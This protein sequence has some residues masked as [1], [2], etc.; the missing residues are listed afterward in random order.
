M[1]ESSREKEPS[2]PRPTQ[3]QRVWQDCEIGIIYHFDLPVAAGRFE[4]NNAVRET[5]DPKNY[6]PAELDTD[7]W[8]EAA[9]A[10]GAQYA[11]FTATHFN[12]FLQWQTDLYP[13]GMKQS[14]YRNGKGDVVAEFVASCRKANILPGLY[15]STHRNVYWTVWG[16][17]VDWGRGKGTPQQKKFNR[18]AEKMT[19]ELCSRYGPL[20]QIWFD[21]GVKTPQEGG[22]DVLP[23]FE[24]YQRNSVFYHN[25]QR[26]D[27]RWI[28]NENGFAND[29]CWATMP[30]GQGKLSH[31]AASWMPLLGSGDRRGTI[32]SPGMVDV[33]LRGAHGI[34]NWFWSPHQDHAAHSVDAL[35]DMF[36]QSVGRNCNLIIGEVVQPNGRVPTSDIERLRAFGRRI[37]AFFGVPLAETSG[38][39]AEL[40]LRLPRPRLVQY[41]SIM[42]DI[43]FGER[44]DE[45]LLEGLLPGHQWK[46]LAR[47]QSVG[48]KRI[49][50]V[51]T[52][53]VTS[54][55]LKVLR[56]PA[57]PKIRKLAAFG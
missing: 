34:H 9:K 14:P 13:Y 11:I 20:V 52:Q 42:E 49:V 16:H 23:I 30:A 21:A 44:I 25:K 22:P 24:K 7:Q 47:G 38:Q 57:P 31:N 1:G 41:V 29:P 54:I 4:A 51:E 5:L 45:F 40:Q 46:E 53:E 8:I 36:L 2:L 6:H 15:F 12:G 28:G 32:W 35:I 17:Y 27:H 33:P 39:G 37:D 18:M 19:E 10:A 48:H 26:S 50:R 43:A 3:A 55:R 56:S